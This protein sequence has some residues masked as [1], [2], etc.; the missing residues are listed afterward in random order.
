MAATNGSNPTVDDV[1]RVV[2]SEFND[3]HDEGGL[4]MLTMQ[5]QMIGHPSRLAITS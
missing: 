5:P 3:A 2:E 1:Y 4:Y